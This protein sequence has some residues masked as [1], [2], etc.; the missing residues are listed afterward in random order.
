[1]QA[2]NPSIA[3]RTLDWSRADVVCSPTR[4]PNTNWWSP[5]GIKTRTKQRNRS[6]ENQ[7]DNC[8][9]GRKDWARVQLLVIS[10]TN[11]FAATVT[12]ALATAICPVTN[13]DNNFASCLFSGHN[14]ADIQAN[15]QLHTD[16]SLNTFIL[17][18]KKNFK[19][20]QQCSDFKEKSRS[21]L[22]SV[23]YV[24]K[25]KKKIQSQRTMT[26]SVCVHVDNFF[27]MCL[28]RSHSHNRT[29]WK[30]NETKQLYNIV[31]THL[32][33]E[34][35]NIYSEHRW[36]RCARCEN[37]RCSVV[38]HHNVQRKKDLVESIVLLLWWAHGSDGRPE[39]SPTGPETCKNE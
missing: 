1:M 36:S 32:M 12:T 17:K 6:K 20:D 11:D 29:H 30:L 21:N 9:F 27:F 35:T 8:K 33:N 37:T 13:P 34:Q 16:L 14:N 26:G 25:A 7:T 39:K 38:S 23:V 3:V 22:V 18:K 15:F 24:T 28:C 2:R 31:L 19:T 4:R 10:Q 5:V